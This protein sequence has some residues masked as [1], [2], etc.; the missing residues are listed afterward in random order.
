MEPLPLFDMYMSLL[1][2]SSSGG[3]GGGE[4]DLS[5][6]TTTTTTTTTTEQAEPIAIATAETSPERTAEMKLFNEV[7]RTG[8]ALLLRLLDEDE[9]VIDKAARQGRQVGKSIVINSDLTI[10]YPT[11]LLTKSHPVSLSFLYHA[12]LHQ[13]VDLNLQNLTLSNF[14][15]YGGP[16]ATEYP[17]GNRGLTLIRYVVQSVLEWCALF[18]C[19]YGVHS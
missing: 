7:S 9:S 3:G 16:I 19:A 14:G 13:Q 5:H 6:V 11:I 18:C 1:K 8:R 10:I 4:A 17:L 12:T 2:E 15:P